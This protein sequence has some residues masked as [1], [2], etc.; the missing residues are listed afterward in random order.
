MSGLD[1]LLLGT[2]GAYAGYVLLRKKKKG[3]CGNCSGCSGCAKS[4]D[5]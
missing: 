1:W 2:I 3:C 4:G 5:S